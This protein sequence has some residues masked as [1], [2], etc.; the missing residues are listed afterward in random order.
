MQPDGIIQAKR[1]CQH[2]E[3]LALLS[4]A[5]PLTLHLP[6]LHRLAGSF[7]FLDGVRLTVPQWLLR[8]REQD[9]HQLLD[10]FD[11]TPREKQE[12]KIRPIRDYG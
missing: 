4:P 5:L 1:G 11:P 12:H 9:A 2:Q 10:I 6:A 8:C 3:P 7:L